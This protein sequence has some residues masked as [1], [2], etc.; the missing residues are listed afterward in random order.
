M[1]PWNPSDPFFSL[2]ATV[3]I[4]CLLISAGGAWMIYAALTFVAGVLLL[5]ARERF[6]RASD[7]VRRA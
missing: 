5:L 4:V 6:L 2:V 1:V 3:W 7:R